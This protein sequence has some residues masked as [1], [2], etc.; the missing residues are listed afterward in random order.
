MKLAG[1]EALISSNRGLSEEK[2]L[3]EETLEEET[4]E[5][6][7]L[8]EEAL[9][10]TGKEEL[11][12][13]PPVSGKL[14]DPFTIGPDT[15]EDRIRAAKAAKAAK[16][17]KAAKASKEKKPVTATENK[18]FFEQVIEKTLQRVKEHLEKTK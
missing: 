3:E 1:Q 8:E 7:T 10:E 12:I 16:A 2:T 15:V 11:R 17:D 13:R 9:E 4:L 6:E 14:T 5:E 18:Q